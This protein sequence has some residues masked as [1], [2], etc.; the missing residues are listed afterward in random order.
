MAKYDIESFISD[1]DT[2]LKANLN[3]QLTVIDAEKNDGI[4]LPP[5]GADAY[6]FQTLNDTVTNYNPFV[7]YGVDQV[8]AEGVGPATRRAYSVDVV[9]CFTDSG[10]D[11]PNVVVKKLFRY[12]RA[13][14]EIF[15]SNWDK[16]GRAPKIKV[17]S[18]VP[19][20]FKFVNS[21]EGFY[22]ARQSKSYPS[23][24]L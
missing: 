16:M 20:S 22:E 9:L 8:E 21:S 18:L 1:L 14:E 17:K 11:A 24:S 7:F 2:F 10:G 13:L 19:V 12:A 23:Q 15:L 6:F 3:T 5:V 4:T